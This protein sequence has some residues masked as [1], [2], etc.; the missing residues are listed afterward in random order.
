M[1]AAEVVRGRGGESPALMVSALLPV[2]TNVA[3]SVRA[4]CRQKAFNWHLR[5][6]L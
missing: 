2:L 3:A 4:H 5:G 6:A 1:A